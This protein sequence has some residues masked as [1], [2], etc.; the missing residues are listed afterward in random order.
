[1]RAGLLSRLRAGLAA[2]RAGL[3]RQ[4][5]CLE[6]F[7]AAL[8]RGRLLRP[9]DH[10]ALYP[11]PGDADLAQLVLVEVALMPLPPALDVVRLRRDVTADRDRLA[12]LLAALGPDDPKLERSE[13]HTSELQ[14]R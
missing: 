6:A 11:A 14:S 7:L 8:D 4:R 1:M 13:E 12:G 5:R 2:I 10:R 9:R 3:R